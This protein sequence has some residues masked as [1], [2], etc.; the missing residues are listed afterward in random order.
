MNEHQGYPEELRQRR[1][2]GTPAGGQG[3][4]PRLQVI[5]VSVPDISII[6]LQDPVTPSQSRAASPQCATGARQRDNQHIMVAH[7]HDFGESSAFSH[8]VSTYIDL[9]REKF[10]WHGVLDPW[11]QNQVGAVWKHD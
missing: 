6:P 1:P 11:Q 2:Y 7:P 5:L 8:T 4:F 9:S 10:K 3:P